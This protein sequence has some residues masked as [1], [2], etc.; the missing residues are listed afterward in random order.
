MA[1]NVSFN[2]T[3]PDALRRD[4]L[5]PG[6]AF[7]YIFPTGAIQELRLVPDPAFSRHDVSDKDIAIGGPHSGTLFDA[8]PNSPVMRVDLHVTPAA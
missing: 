4:Q 2:L 8:R 6:E 5:S 7:V 3:Q 1:I